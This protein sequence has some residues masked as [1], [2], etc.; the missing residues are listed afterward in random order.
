MDLDPTPLLPGA[1]WNDREPPDGPR[2]DRPSLR[3]AAWLGARRGIQ[4]TAAMTAFRL[5][6]SRSPPPPSYLVAK[7]FGGD[8][9]RYPI[10]G[11]VLHFVYGAAAGAVFGAWFERRASGTDAERERD[12]VL[13]GSLYG[14]A[15]SAFGNRVLMDRLL[16]LDLADDERFVFHVSHL[17]YG[18]TL[19]TALGSDD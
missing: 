15:L 2:T 14:M 8:A 3:R 19:G 16:G 7:P 13:L 12:G 1:E 4:A 6:I 11:M 5:P 18:L 9:R 17:V 10:T